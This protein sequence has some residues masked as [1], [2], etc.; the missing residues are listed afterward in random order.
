MNLARA[1]LTES[2]RTDSAVQL[3]RILATVVAF[4]LC[5]SGMAAQDPGVRSGPANAG[6]MLPGLT[7]PERELFRA[8]LE[9]FVRLNSVQGERLIAGTEA[10]LGPTF[11]MDSCA[12]CHAFPAVGGSSPPR[13]PQV[14]VAKRQGASNVIP[15]FV[16]PTG[17]VFQVRLQRRID[18]TVDGSVHALFTIAGRGDAPGCFMP[19]P[20]FGRELARGNA[21]V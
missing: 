5:T 20:D 21:A 1:R 3:A 18:G 17:P 16:L 19:Q 9:A 13:N 4:E 10:G 11:N 2:L 8:G 15:V 7:R 6:T 12:G 14:L